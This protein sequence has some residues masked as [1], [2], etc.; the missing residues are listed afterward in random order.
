MKRATNIAL[1]TV[2]LMVVALAVASIWFSLSFRGG[3]VF[4]KV[5]RIEHPLPANA[6]QT[7]SE[8]QTETPSEGETDF[9]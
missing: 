8:A 1:I 4:F 6:I 7:I 5:M 3:Q 2:R 9:A